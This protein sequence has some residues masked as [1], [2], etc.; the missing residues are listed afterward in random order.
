MILYENSDGRKATLMI[1]ANL[2]SLSTEVDLPTFLSVSISN[3]QRGTLIIQTKLLD[4]KPILSSYVLC[5]FLFWNHL[6]IFAAHWIQA[7]NL[8]K[9]A[10]R[11][12]PSLK[13]LEQETRLSETAE[14]V[15]TPASPWLHNDGT[16]WGIQPT[17]LSLLSANLATM[18]SQVR[19]KELSFQWQPGP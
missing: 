11:G 5:A 7:R 16:V 14:A 6:G 12:M 8:G 13:H 3:R 9:T 1:K 18:N 15:R 17:T 19:I 4:H 10:S 2:G